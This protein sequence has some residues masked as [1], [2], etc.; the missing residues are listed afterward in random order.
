MKQIYLLILLLLS[1]IGFSQNEANVWYFGNNAGLDFNSG[2]PVALTNGQMATLEGCASIANNSGQLQF[3]T[4]GVTVWNKNH[5]I[6][7]NGTELKGHFS[8]TQSAIIIPLPSSNTQYIIFTVDDGASFDGLNYSV[9][10]MSLNGGLGEVTL[11]NVQLIAPTL[12]KVTAVKHNN[13][14]DIWVVTHERGSNAFYAYLV[15]N[16]GVQ[17]TPVIT[18]IGFVYNGI[19][20]SENA[21]YMKA[22]PNGQRLAM[23]FPKPSNGLQLFDF[24]NATGVVSNHINVYDVPGAFRPYGVEFSP[25]GDILYVSGTGGIS[26]FDITF[27]NP[28]DIITSVTFLSNEIADNFWRAMQLAPDEKIYIT[29]MA[30]DNVPDINTLS[31]INEPDVLGAGCNFQLDTISLGTGV[32]QSGLPPFI[33]SFFQVGITTENNCL[34]NETQFQANISESYDSILWDFGD[35]NTSS[36]Q[37]PSHTY[38][39][40]GIYTVTVT[41]TSGTETTSNTAE[42]TI[43]D[44]PTANQPSNI[45]VC[46]D[47]NDGLY[48]FDLTTQNTLILNGQSESIFEVLYYVSINDFNNEN[49]ITTPE[50]YINTTP[51]GAQTIIASVRNIE[52]NNC[53]D[54][55]TFSIQVFE[56]PTP[57]QNV[58]NISTCDNTSFGT[59]NDGIILFDLT[60][61]ET[62]ILNGQSETLFSVNY[63]TDAGFANQITSPNAYQNT[64]ANETI[65]VQVVNNN[66]SNCV[67]E[68]YFNIEVNE[69]PLVNSIVELKQC[70]DDL[71]GFSIFNLHE[72]TNEISV[73]ASTE[74]VTFYESEL[75]AQNESNPIANSNFYINQTVSTDIVWA[76]IENSNSCTRTSQI[77]LIVSTTQIPSS[78]TRDF[79]ECDDAINGTNSD[80]ISSFDFSIVN[81]EIE[82]LF[83]VGQQ[84]IIS[85]YRNQTDALTEQNSITD[86]S[87]Y[88]NIG[89]PNTQNI[90]I[91]VDSA[92]DNDCLG[93]GDHITLH[94]ETVPVANSV[95]VPEECDADGDGIFEFDTS[96][97]ENTLLNGQTNVNVSY[98]DENGTSLPSPLPNPFITSSQNIIARV[99]NL[100]SLDAEGACYAETVIVFTVEAAAVANP[101]PQQS[102]CDDDSD[103]F[104]AFDTST[105]ETTVLNGQTGMIVTYT[106]ENGD[107]LPSPL[108]NPFI[109]SSQNITLRVENPLNSICYDETTL[110][111][112]VYQTPIAFQ[113]ENDIICDD[114]SNDG[115]AVFTLSNYNTQVLN[116]QPNAIFEVNYFESMTEAGNNVNSLPNNYTVTT[117]SEEVFVRVHNINNPSC[118]DITSFQLGVV[119][120]P[121]ANQPNDIFVCDGE[122]NDGFETFDLT[123]QNV[124]ILGTQ[125]AT[126]NTI[127]YH[128]SQN[129]ADN[130]NNP[131]SPLF[132]NTSNPQTIY[133]RLENN[134]H[135]DCYTTTAFSVNVIEQPLLLMDE[136]WSICEN[137]SIEIVADTGYDEYLWSTGDTTPVIT[138]D[139]AGTYELTVANVLDGVRCETSKIITV[140]ESTIATIINVETTDW[141]QNDNTISIQ[142]EGSGDYEYSIDGVNYQDSNIFNNLLIDDYL[143]YVRDKNGC[144]IITEEVYLLYYPNFFTPNG[145]GYNE[146]WQ[147]L[148]SSKEP[149]NRVYIFD[150][151]G[152]ILKELK[153]NDIGWDGTYNGNP[154]PSTDYW[155]IVERQ[156]GKTY[157][158]N[159]SLKR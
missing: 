6:M 80:G 45:L 148:N 136:Q 117:S 147:L 62:A 79:Y 42:V 124:A 7:A 140:L 66:N 58:P 60:Q 116:G 49:P 21:G 13:G 70:D 87:N 153:P 78:F 150:R 31:V 119:Y 120:F 29:R 63:F 32:A 113:I 102:T 15:T 157:K 68:T 130:G 75:D 30:D 34:G 50:A 47:N 77:N 126:E 146:T 144:G 74:T 128:L 99:T 101:V 16:T 118:Y 24:D 17:S 138:V 94:V 2:T 149:F 154:M 67:A 141:T 135:T 134:T 1:N 91:R 52:N 129:D 132:T 3:Y 89:Y 98:T 155:F 131:L 72:V 25:S 27:S 127:T 54:S 18:N 65:Y 38:L 114:T 37:T 53:E 123:D 71:D 8:S 20:F 51:Y 26:Q 36:I 145:D 96:N 152:K 88:R 125:S 61:N 86:I 133:A 73:N 14:N 44:Q 121:I 105:I 142:V 83:P 95:I 22:S 151:F 100:N 33:Q 103:G 139:Q 110:E 108:P 28:F 12:E 156:N 159:F 40:A 56:F 46:D 23:V 97:I 93:L 11:K 59:D 107:L 9:V 90:Y 82:A 106:D 137:E 92:L 39:N 4:D 5:S 81:S 69:L 48:S 109:T 41:V 35:G 112:L 111:F 158:G 143:V 57:N 19:S 122:E 115:Q 85:Y 64:T 55:T 43:Y 10:D 84:L 76:R 104:A